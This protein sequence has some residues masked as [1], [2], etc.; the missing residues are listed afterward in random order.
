MPIGPETKGPDFDVRMDAAVE[1]EWKRRRRLFRTYLALLAVPVL[2]AG[3]AFAYGESTRQVVTHEVTDKVTHEVTD[4]VTRVVEKSVT[5]QVRPQVARL[6]REESR[7][8][9]LSAVRSEVATTVRG[10]AAVQ[11]NYAAIQ[12]EQAQIKST[13]AS[14]SL[15]VQNTTRHAQADELLNRRITALESQVTSLQKELGAL[16][17]TVRPRID[18]QPIN[19]R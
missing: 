8:V 7:P 14:L 15:A 9:I 6:V 18:R 19:P 13:I 4:N 2:A 3:I 17:G 16:R 1:R 5:E 11:S 12:D 10:M